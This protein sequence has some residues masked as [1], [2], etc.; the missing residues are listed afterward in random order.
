MKNAGANFQFVYRRW[1]FWNNHAVAT[2]HGADITVA[3]PGVN[4]TAEGYGALPFSF[5]MGTVLVLVVL[6]QTVN[7]TPTK[8][9]QA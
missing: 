1:N 9:S 4:T 2:G 3:V 5:Y 7:V 8:Q 6:F